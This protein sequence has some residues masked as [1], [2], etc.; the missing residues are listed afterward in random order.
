M[1][2]VTEYKWVKLF[3]VMVM[4][5]LFLA[6]GVDEAKAD[7]VSGFY[8]YCTEMTGTTETAVVTKYNG[9]AATVTIPEKING[10][11]VTGIGSSAFS[12]NSDLKVV[13]IPGSVTHID[14]HA[15]YG[16]E[17][18]KSANLSKVEIIGEAAFQ[19]TKLG[20]IKLTKVKE[21]A[22]NAFH[23]CASLTKVDFGEHEIESIDGG[24]FYG[25]SIKSVT[26]S[27]KN[28]LNSDY[29][30]GYGYGNGIFANCV[31]LKSA[32]IITSGKR[33][34]Y[35]M[36]YGCTALTDVSLDDAITKIGYNVFAGCSSLKSIKL[37]KNLTDLDCRWGSGLL[38]FKNCT[39]LESIEIPAGVRHFYTDNFV[40][41]TSLKKVKLNEGLTHIS[42]SGYSGNEI[43]LS[44]W[45]MK[46]PKTVTSIDFGELITD[47][48]IIIPN[49]VKNAYSDRWSGISNYP[50]SYYSDSPLADTFAYSECH[51]VLDPTPAKSVKLNKK[52]MTVQAGSTFKLKATLA[53]TNTT[54]AITWSTTNSSIAQVDELGNVTT[55][56]AGM[57]V[58]R[59]TTTS[60]LKAD[61]TL[62]VKKG[63]SEITLD[64]S[65]INMGKGE[66]VVRK[67]KVDKEAY[68]KTITYESSDPSIVS[69]D[70]NGK[71]K[72]LKI[73]TATIKAVA[74]N[75]LSKAYTVNVKKAPGKVKIVTY[76]T[77]HAGYNYYFRVELPENTASY[78]LKYSVDNKK[79]ATYDEESRCLKAKKAGTVTL[80]VKTFNGK[81]ASKKIKIE[82]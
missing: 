64:T 73:G 22:K 29:K 16:C 2:K 55:Y 3:V 19:N 72:G 74:S 81:K 8:E 75:G 65:T 38:T 14:Y 79:L 20:S 54:D 7:Q 10:F 44:Q 4:S 41:C 45:N 32:T 5:A 58:I 59:A 26:V 62:T 33:I 48:S 82:K 77:A 60:N 66:T 49:S 78:N 36:F 15:F 9:V 21:I 1:T 47:S 69:V 61:F 35:S 34:S 27:C 43:T 39:A 68:N 31:K 28:F 17:N 70:K 52:K 51:T 25:T 37:P 40:G 71:I 80:T 63:P 46:I 50:F 6:I 56:S 53:P 57:V 13:K 11:K 67:A 12:G 23:D 76:S 24:A 42:H 18:L 30:D